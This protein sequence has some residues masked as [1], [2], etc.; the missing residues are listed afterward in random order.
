VWE[1]LKRHEKFLLAALGEGDRA[2]LELLRASHLRRLHDFQHERLIHLLVTLFVAL[3]SMLAIG[4]FLHAPSIAG[5][6]LSALLLALTTAYLLHYFRL[7]NGVQRLEALSLRLDEA[8][9]GRPLGAPDA[10]RGSPSPPG[11]GGA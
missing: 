4:W 11:G 5:M 3:F 8:I 10:D 6:A 1:E 9:A 7:E 2:A